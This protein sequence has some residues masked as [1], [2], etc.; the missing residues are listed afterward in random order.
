M[1]QIITWIQVLVRLSSIQPKKKTEREITD[2]RR[3]YGL[4]K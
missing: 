1:I 3:I 4:E 2:Q